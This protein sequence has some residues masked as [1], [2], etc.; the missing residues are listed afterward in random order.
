M[1][2]HNH[3]ENCSYESREVL[4]Q[5]LGANS[6]AEQAAALRGGASALQQLPLD[7]QKQRSKGNT[8]PRGRDYCTNTYLNNIIHI[9]STP[10]GSQREHSMRATRHAIKSSMH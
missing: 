4:L 8:Q 6:L 10:D 5:G 9:E 7:G 1:W 3:L 2:L